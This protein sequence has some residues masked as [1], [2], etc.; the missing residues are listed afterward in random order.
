MSVVSWICSRAAM[1]GRRR[2]RGRS[3]TT[4][5]RRAR[6]WRSGSTRR[7][8]RPAKARSAPTATDSSLNRPRPSTTGC[9][10][11]AA[12][13]S[14]S[15]GGNLFPA[16]YGCQKE[17]RDRRWSVEWLRPD[18]DDVEALIICDRAT[19][20][21]EP[22]GLIVDAALRQR[23]LATIDGLGLNRP[24]L[25]RERWRIARTLYAGSIEGLLERAEEGPYRF[26]S[27]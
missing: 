16:C 26:L 20:K 23:V 5:A 27:P 12:R 25:V 7:C 3:F 14:R 4:G 8:G 1:Q 15:G 13:S 19:G 18:L 17:K 24:G 10:S 9:P 6:R 11:S 2:T 22:S 21:L